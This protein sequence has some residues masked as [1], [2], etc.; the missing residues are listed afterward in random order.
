MTKKFLG[1][2]S[3]KPFDLFHYL[4]LVGFVIL[5]YYLSVWLNLMELVVSNPV[6]GWVSLVSVYYVVLLLGDN[7][8][9]KIG[10]QY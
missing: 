2:I 1:F 8:I 3:T 6:L 9:H 7:L 5:G 10:G 4:P